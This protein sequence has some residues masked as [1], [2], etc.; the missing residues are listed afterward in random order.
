M[1]LCCTVGVKGEVC[2]IDAGDLSM[3][4]YI[5]MRSVHKSD[6]DLSHFRGDD[7][8]KCHSQNW[9]TSSMDLWKERQN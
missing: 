9:T 3:L 5:I 1:G 8:N 7:L 6:F 4:H 2:H